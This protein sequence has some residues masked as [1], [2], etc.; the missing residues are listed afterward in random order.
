MTLQRTEIAEDNHRR[1]IQRAVRSGAV[2][3]LKSEDET[4]VVSPSNHDEDRRV[5]PFW[6]DEA[7]ARRCRKGPWME[8]L[9][10]AIPLDLFLEKWLPGLDQRGEFVGTNWDG[11]LC[12]ME[13]YPLA[14]KQQLEEALQR[15]NS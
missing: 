7:Y 10:T 5:M 11:N 1:F 14:L 3:G 9:P 15:P 6:S 8:F 13:V 12:G 4:W 2:W